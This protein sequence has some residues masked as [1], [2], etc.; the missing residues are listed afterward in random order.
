MGNY[1]PQMLQMIMQILMS[2]VNQ[3]PRPGLQGP[4]P[5]MGQPGMRPGMPQRPMMP[6]GI[7]PGMGRPGGMMPRGNPQA[8]AA[9]ASL[10]GQ[11]GMMGRV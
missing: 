4:S 7:R 3:Q 10:M 1:S 2:R 5:S 6:G 11:Q 8:M 9:L